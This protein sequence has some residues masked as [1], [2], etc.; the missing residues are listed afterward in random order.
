MPHLGLHQR[1]EW[2]TL[3]MVAVVSIA[4]RLHT[5]FSTEYMPGN[6]G[7]YYLIM[8]RSMLEKG[9]LIRAD[10]PLL[11][12]LE[13]G[14]SFIV[15]KLGLTNINSAIDITT[16]VFDSI[17]P[18]FSIIPAYLLT[19]KLLNGKGDW[20]ISALIS[21]LSILYYSFL[22]LI[23]DFQK[24][25]LGLLWLFWLIYFLLCVHE[26]ATLK[27]ILGVF[28]FLVLTGLTHYGCIVVGITII[29][30]DL[31]ARH[32]FYYSL[33]RFLK[34]S[35]WLIIAIIIPVGLMY[36]INPWRVR[37][38]VEIPF[39]IFKDPVL[40]MIIRKEPVI[41]PI[42]T[43]SLILMNVLGVSS[44]PLFIKHFK[45]VRET[46]RSF[47][48][49]N[50]IL[51]L[52]LSSPLL[53][54]E[55]AQRVYF[56]SYLA[57]IPILTFFYIAFCR[58]IHSNYFMLFLFIVILSSTILVLARPNYSNMNKDL[59]SEMLKIKNHISVNEKTVIIARHGM[60]FWSSW[61]FGCDAF[62]Q[63]S[64]WPVYWVWY[65]NI[66]IIHQK[67][68]KPPFG[69]AGIYGKPFPEPELPEESFL[70]YRSESFDLYQAPKPPKDFYKYNLG[71]TK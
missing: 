40:L 44:I 22:I 2:L 35:A 60:E 26:K 30:I 41:T 6:N 1:K 58:K 25:S 64:V 19:K 46:H 62:R 55:Y 52:F 13:A 65:K 33:K 54:F 21:A 14:I 42:D 37:T 4:I 70:I 43:L 45:D 34:L 11:F 24:N 9:S 18:V 29:I 71:K 28:I 61:V 31:L 51:L 23:S 27:N 63:E 57:A 3:A 69:P 38:F 5:N 68:D 39:E 59:Y 12:W 32:F 67:K 48:L 36:F 17:I 66:Y 8:V 7:A 56:I 20:K 50:I 49:S 16:R 47:I 53:S 10:F 15:I